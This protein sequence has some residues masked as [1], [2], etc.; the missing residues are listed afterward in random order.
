MFLN[1]WLIV[2]NN[3]NGFWHI[4]EEIN[5]QV[6]TGLDALTLDCYMGLGYI[7]FRLYNPA[8]VLWSILYSETLTSCLIITN[9]LSGRQSRHLNDDKLTFSL[10]HPYNVYLSFLSYCVGWELQHN[11]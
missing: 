3:S 2:A 9:K 10:V 1:V 6:T 8:A 7:N 11:I 4:F 5:V